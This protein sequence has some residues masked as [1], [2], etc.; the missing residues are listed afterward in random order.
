MTFS[1]SPPFFPLAISCQARD[2]PPRGGGRG[3]ER[4]NLES[5]IFC[6][7]VGGCEDLPLCA[8]A[9][10]RRKCGETKKSKACFLLQP[11]FFAVSTTVD[12]TASSFS[13]MS[14]VSLA[15]VC[16]RNTKS[17]TLIHHKKDRKKEGRTET[18]RKRPLIWN[19]GGGRNGLPSS[20][21]VSFFCTLCVMCAGDGTRPD[22]TT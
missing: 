4:K 2:L 16:R 3:R 7:F 18:E 10:E 11:L 5:H 17:P 14:G 22:F 8:T 19:E 9:G 20:L 1:S 21:A 15:V 6:S 12:V 13:S